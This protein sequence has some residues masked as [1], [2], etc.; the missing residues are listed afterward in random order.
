MTFKTE[1]KKLVVLASIIIVAL[2]ASLLILFMNYSP[3][4]NKNN[5]PEANE[6]KPASDKNSKKLINSAMENRQKPSENQPEKSPKSAQKQESSAE[7]LHGVAIGARYKLNIK[8][9]LQQK[10]YF[11]APT[12]VSMMLSAR[13]IAADQ[14]ILAQEMGTYEPFGTHN[15]DAVRVLNKHMFGYE[16]PQAGQA[17]YRLETVKTVDQKTI[18][19]FKQRLIKNTKDGYPMYYTINPAK[20]YPGA[21]NSEHNVAGAGYIATPDGTDVALIYYIDPYPNFQD[22]VYGGLKVMTPEELLQ[23]T[24]GVSEPNYAW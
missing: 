9:Q 13:N 23:A 20:V 15:R 24:V 5:H 4:Y 14:T 7:N 8:P 22:P 1:R 11:C 16:L 21:N 3:K 18:E 19:L 12:T 6:T 10:W 2:I 17:G